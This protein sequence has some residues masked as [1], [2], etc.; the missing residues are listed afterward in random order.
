MATFLSD[1]LRDAQITTDR[2][3]AAQKQW[4]QAEWNARAAFA[5]TRL[6]TLDKMWLRLSRADQFDAAYAIWDDYIDGRRDDERIDE[7]TAYELT[8]AAMV[9]TRAVRYLDA[10]N[11]VSLARVAWGLRIFEV[12][13]AD[14]P[15]SGWV[16]KFCWYPLQETVAVI[17][18]AVACGCG[19]THP[20]T[21][22]TFTPR[23]VIRTQVRRSRP[24]AL[25]P[26]FGVKA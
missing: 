1:L 21:S 14:S 25:H 24:L 9:F 4:E 8:E 15:T 23:G 3:I 5:L 10:A 22:D 13:L 19:E 12:Y 18:E 11:I 17:R 26:V 2:M 16:G 20:G 7:A 6:D